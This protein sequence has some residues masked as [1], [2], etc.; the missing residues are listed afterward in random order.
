VQLGHLPAE[1]DRAVAENGV[2]IVEHAEDAV[3]R[4]EEEERA[5]LEP[6]LFECGAPRRPARR[7]EADEGERPRWKAA[8]RQQGRHCRRAGDRHDPMTR[9]PRAAHQ[10]RSGIGETGGP[11]VGDQGHAIARGE[12]GE[13]FRR[14]PRLIELVVADHPARQTVTRHQQPRLARIF[15]G[16]QAAGAEGG[17][18]AR[19]Q[20]LQVADRGA[21][22]VQGA[23]SRARVVHC[24]SG[25]TGPSRAGSG[26]RCSRCAARS[27]RSAAACA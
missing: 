11:G 18:R 3:R 7:Q 16:D 12:G 14:P 13:E 5:R 8:R 17:D 9:G 23:V 4:F 24:G 15:G 6:K 20:I 10:E 21:D 22:D 1:A 27:W 25:A 26:N 19:R 2:Q